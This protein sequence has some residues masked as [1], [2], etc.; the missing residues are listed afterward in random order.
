[1]GGKK[2]SSK[3]EVN[4]NTIL[5]QETKKKKNLTDNLTLHLKQLEI[6]E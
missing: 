4:S 5:N 2:S 3:R 1:M 6:E